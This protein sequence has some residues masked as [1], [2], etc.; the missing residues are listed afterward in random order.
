MSRG[1][2]KQ[3]IFLNNGDRL[4]FV[5]KLS[6]VV[7]SCEWS[8]YAYCLMD[9]HFHLLIETP[10]ANISD[11]M[12]MLNS[13]YCDYFKRKHDG[14]G[15][16]LQGRFRSPL[17]ENEAYLMAII[18]YIAINPVEAGLVSEPEQWRWSSYSAICGL[19]PAPE[20]LDVGYTLR[21][22]S[23]DIE[24][25]RKAYTRFV[26]EGPL[27]ERLTDQ[28]GRLTLQ[29][30]FQGVWNKRLRNMAI[31]IAHFKFDY[32]INEIAA[33]LKLNR[34]TVSRVLKA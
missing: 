10:Q 13:D 32:K 27:L 26:A 31:R 5:R 19:N 1:S 22:F 14:V 15:H 20:F 11:G 30:L 23:D 7:T 6:R 9:N 24:A 25:A 12:H 4:N 3:K 29:E 33:H 18:R 21:I 16:V 2:L 17:I 28:M 34:A 8:C